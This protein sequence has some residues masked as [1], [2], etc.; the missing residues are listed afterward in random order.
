MKN[1]KLTPSVLFFITFGM[2][3]FL[4]WVKPWHWTVYLESDISRMIGLIV[5]LISFI[6]N[7]LAYR[8]FKK[9]MTPHAPFSVPHF[10]ID[11]GIFSLSRNPVYLALVLAQCGLGFVFDT[12]W[13]LC[14]AL[15]L[16]VTLQ[17]LVILFEEKMMERMFKE[18][19]RYYKKHT[20]R[21][22]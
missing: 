4:S 17:Y 13:L 15:V 7:S 21:W 19:Y 8:M 1:P 18:R 16:M 9:Y 12:V 20:R 10:L 5:L 6:L 22:F 11:R 3:I 2:G 14:T